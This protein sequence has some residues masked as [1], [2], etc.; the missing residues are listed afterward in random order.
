MNGLQSPTS[1]A[2]V[3]RQLSAPPL[4]AER[5][6]RSGV[7]PRLDADRVPVTRELGGLGDVLLAGVGGV[8]EV[9]LDL[10]TVRELAEPVAAGLQPELVEHRLR[11]ALVELQPGVAPL[12]VDLL[13]L[14]V[15]LEA[16]PLGAQGS[17]G[18]L[19][20]LEV[21]GLLRLGPVVGVR[22]RDPELL[23]A[24]QVAQ[25]LVRVLVV[26]ER[27]RPGAGAGV[28]GE[29]LDLPPGLGC[30]ELL[31]VGEGQRAV[32]AVHVAELAGGD[33]DLLHLRV[34]GHQPL[35]RVEVRQ[36]VA[37]LADHVVVG[38]A[39]PDR[40]LP[41]LERLDVPAGHRRVVRI[42]VPVQLLVVLGRPSRPTSH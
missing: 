7:E 42:L 9:D 31:E 1:H 13:R 25:L 3:R 34:V 24:D 11:L 28:P 4:V 16:R 18:Q 21:D 33:L 30:L 20:L 26:E 14:V 23:L 10:A 27:D 12:R 35:D 5:R 15:H 37:V 41:L 32:R 36:L 22:E 29:D 8:V 6:R 40:G 19:A 17:R 39:L 2:L 38:V